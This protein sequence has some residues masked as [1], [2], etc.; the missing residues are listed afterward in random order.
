MEAHYSDIFTVRSVFTEN[1]KKKLSASQIQRIVDF[2]YSHREYYEELFILL[3]ENLN[4]TPPLNR[5]NVFYVLDSLCKHASKLHFYGYVDQ[6]MAKL[7]EIVSLVVDQANK[8]D[9]GIANVYQLRKVL[10][11]WKVKAILRNELFEQ[12]DSSLKIILE[13]VIVL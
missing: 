13:K 5:L 12:I 2:C 6:I 7:E 1:I 8:S 9:D 3:I 4:L 10:T 11:Q